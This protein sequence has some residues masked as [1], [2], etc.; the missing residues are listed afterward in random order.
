MPEFRE[1][2]SSAMQREVRQRCGFGCVFCGKPFY[3]YDHIEE[4]SEVKEHEVD[5]L[6]LLCP[7]HH[8]EKTNR[9]RSKEQVR[10]AN[11]NPF[12]RRN[13]SSSPYLLAY[14]GSSCTVSVGSNKFVQSIGPAY[15]EPLALNGEPLVKI[16]TEEG[17]L[18]LS[19]KLSDS[20]GSTILSI[21]ENVLTYDTELWDVTFV[22]N[23]LVVREG[24]RKVTAKIVFEPPSAITI[25]RGY[26]SHEGLLVQVTPREIIE[27]KCNNIISGITVSDVP[28]VR[29]ICITDAE[30]RGMV[31]P[32]TAAI[33]FITAPC[34]EVSR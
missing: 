2:I 7:E 34:V 15:K 22:A 28:F 32:S 16:R 30:H 33:R 13:P 24:R 17:H 27:K 31:P 19:A 20:S 4:W 1:A 18:L 3:D 9:L 21:E 29:G 26:F 23:T 14:D 6:T 10:I 25:E 11:A 8:R 5:N 12:N